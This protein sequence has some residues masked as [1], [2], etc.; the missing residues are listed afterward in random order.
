VATDEE[1][2]APGRIIAAILLA[3]FAIA[4]FAAAVVFLIVGHHHA[5]RAAGGFLAGLVFLV[6][7]WFA[8]RYRS[9]AL[10]AAREA[11][12][13]AR[14]RT[15]GQ[16]ATQQD[17]RGGSAGPLTDTEPM[18]ISRDTEPMDISRS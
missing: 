3:V 16:R 4:F 8:L 1:K 10:E 15:A 14:Q 7:A 12:Q 6:A 17:A 2:L 5:L 18:D 13:A 9:P 11:D